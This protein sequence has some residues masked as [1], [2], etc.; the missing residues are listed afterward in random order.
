MF[1]ISYCFI[2]YKTH[3]LSDNSFCPW[4]T[5]QHSYLNSVVPFPNVY[6]PTVN[7]YFSNSKVNCFSVE[8]KYFRFYDDNLFFDFKPLTHIDYNLQYNKLLSTFNKKSLSIQNGNSKK[9]TTDLNTLKTKFDKSVSRFGTIKKSKRF[10]FPVSLDQKNILI[11]WMNE[12]IKF[13]NYIKD[14]YNHNNGKITT[15]FRQ[16]KKIIFDKFYCGKK[17]PIPYDILTDEVKLFCQNVKSCR[18]NL[19]KG[20]IAHFTMGER[21]IK[22]FFSMFIPQSAVKYNGFYVSLLGRI[23]NWWTKIDIN[24]IDGDCKL[25][26]DRL[27]DKFYFSYVI[28]EK[29]KTITNREPVCGID[30][31]EVVFL[32]YYGL[33]SY[34]KIGENIRVKIL[35]NEKRIRKLNQAL[36]TKKNKKGK[37]IKHKKKIRKKLNK[38]YDKTKNVVKDLHNKSALFLCKKYD[39]I[40]IPKFETQKMTSNDRK[41]AKERVKQKIKELK[42][43]R[44]RLKQYNR[45]NRLNK[46]VKYVL[47]QLAHYS[48]RK[49]LKNKCEEYGCEYM[50][51][52]EEYTSQLCTECIRL[53]KKYN[54]RIKEC[55]YCGFEIERDYNGSRNIIIKNINKV[56]L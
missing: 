38:L 25:I 31:G 37:R 53:S 51:V 54:G 52:T 45:Q 43:N 49:H 18:T 44:T 56:M 4:W 11:V 6:D 17:K 35:E 42:E 8:H 10:K 14:Y 2:L 47:N 7:I 21:R 39:R 28:K 20:N 55:T 16:L 30:P 29:I 1:R 33:N 32:T 26:Y 13:Y 24:D 5:S 27:L 46:R 15:D 12:C 3:I 19:I 9:K 22:R 23:D 40:L 41:S 50:E 36:G 48:F 34:G